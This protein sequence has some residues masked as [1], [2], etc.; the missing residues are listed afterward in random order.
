MSDP[1]AR[2]DYRRH[3]ALLGCAAVALVA[4]LRI[5]PTAMVPQWW[6]FALYG[7]LHALAFVGAVRGPVSVLKQLVFIAA[8]SML[9][10]AAPYIG[11]CAVR[12][13]GAGPDR[14]SLFALLA[15]SS[16]IGALSYGVLIRRFW[17]PALPAAAF[18][19]IA[20]GCA[21]G[22]LLAVVAARGS[23]LLHQ[24]LT[25]L[26][27]ITFSCGLWIC[28]AASGLSLARSQQ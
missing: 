16:G 14:V 20:L 17:L 9:A 25:L 2:L 6:Q 5:W 10:F 28:T 3:F 8:A 13:I 1:V 19:A 4:V 11:I 24:S 12:F 15:L 7:L 21:A 26:W 22:T 27:W 18:G 23:P